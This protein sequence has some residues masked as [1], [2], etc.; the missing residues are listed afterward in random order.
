MSAP[1]TPRAFP[2]NAIDDRF[3]GMTLRDWFAGQA[4]AGIVAIT[5]QGTRVFGPAAAAREAFKHADEMLAQRGE[6]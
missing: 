6:R 1:E 3:G 4:L 2:S 5:F